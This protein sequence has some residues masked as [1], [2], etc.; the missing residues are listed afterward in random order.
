MSKNAKWILLLLAVSFLTGCGA[1][2]GDV[3]ELIEPVAIQADRAAAYIGEIYTTDTYKGV[4]T[5]YVEKLAFPVDGRV[6][7]VQT[8]AGKEVKAGEV[9]AELDQTAL[10]KKARQL[11]ED[12]EFSEKDNEY[13][14]AIAELEIQLLET[15]LRQM[16][17]SGAYGTKYDTKAL[18]LEEKRAA[19]RQTQELR[20][21]R[22]E[23]QRRELAQTEEALERSVLR[24]PFS[25]RIISCDLKSG[26]SV[27]AYKPV[28]FLVDESRLFLSSEFV[29]DLKFEGADRIYALIGSGVYD[30]KPLPFDQ[31]EF[32]AKS[33][34]GV[35]PRSYSEI[36]GPKEELSLLEVGQ[37]AEVC[38]IDHYV[39]DALIVPSGA[40]MRDAGGRYVYVD[41]NGVRE[42]RS[43]KVGITNDALAQIIEGLEEGEV[44]Y[45]KE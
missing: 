29:S 36:L 27:S 23:A 7:I 30:V 37:F 3:P 22:L 19:L 10:E 5:A 24:A 15:E 44:V 16:E 33:L 40:L 1:G 2:K 12:L 39:P 31:S 6:K 45:V 14:D 43:V 28:V 25:G 32:I 34:A 21:P 38:L 13:A 9:L 4:V 35:E 8:Y 20:E 42:H 18:D 17:A 26:E 11:R 41:V